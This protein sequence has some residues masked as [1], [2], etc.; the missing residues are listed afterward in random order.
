[1]INDRRNR[2]TVANGRSLRVNTEHLAKVSRHLAG[3][4]INCFPVGLVVQPILTDL[5]LDVGIVAGAVITGTASPRTIIP[6]HGLYRCHSPIRQLADPEIQACFP[7]NMI[8]VVPV[9]VLA[10]KI[11]Q[12]RTIGS[13][14]IRLNISLQ[15]RII[16]AGRMPQDSLR[17]KFA[18]PPVAGALRHHTD[19][20]LVLIV[21]LHQ[22]LLSPALLPGL[23]A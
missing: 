1:M 16:C 18:S 8:P 20:R 14:I 15:P 5:K 23:R 2:H 7:L 21:I 17:C 4:L 6:G 10:Q 13:I 11:Q 3:F 9:L 19:Q 22:V 12:F